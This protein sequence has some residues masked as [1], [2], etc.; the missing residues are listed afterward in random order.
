MMWVTFGSLVVIFALGAAQDIMFPDDPNVDDRISGNGP[1]PTERIPL[2]SPSQ[3]PENMLLYAGDGNISAWI[4]DCIAGYLYFPLNNSCHEAYR[5]GPC[6]PQHYVILPPGEVVPKCEKNP[7][8]EDGLVSYNG[9]CS[10]VKTNEGPCP[11]KGILTVNET[12]FQLECVP[13]NIGGLHIIDAPANR[14]PNGSR[15]NGLGQCRKM[16]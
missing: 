13:P 5:Q 7:C 9:T 15:R 11:D 1:P 4:C 2:Y 3:C 16:I 6:A 12:T 8:L 14:C 10:R